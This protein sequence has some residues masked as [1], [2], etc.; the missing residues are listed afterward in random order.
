MFRNTHVDSD[1]YEGYLLWASPVAETMKKS[2]IVT[3]IVR[4]IWMPVIHYMLG[5]KTLRGKLTYKL[6]SNFSLLV[7]RSKIREVHYA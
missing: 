3:Q 7:L 6:L 5:K 1:V 2:K 4:A